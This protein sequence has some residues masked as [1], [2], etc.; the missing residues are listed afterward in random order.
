MRRTW[1]EKKIVSKSLKI[2][3]IWHL[4]QYFLFCMHKC[5]QL[6]TDI[7]IIMPRSQTIMCK[8]VIGT[9]PADKHTCTTKTRLYYCY[10]RFLPQANFNVEFCFYFIFIKNKFISPLLQK[11][12]NDRLKHTVYRRGCGK[13][14]QLK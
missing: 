7:P 3:K 6:L 9:C 12:K 8:F 1:R 10:I 14:T 13:L 5:K 2:L 4:E 11:K